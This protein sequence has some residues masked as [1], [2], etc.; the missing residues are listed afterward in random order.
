MLEVVSSFNL[1]DGGEPA[2]VGIQ[3]PH[4]E[5]KGKHSAS[6]RVVEMQRCKGLYV[7]IIRHSACINHAF[8]FLYSDALTS[9]ALPT[10]ED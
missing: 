5:N 6:P 10:L 7:P 9:G 4:L 2:L 3:F 8:Y 1:L